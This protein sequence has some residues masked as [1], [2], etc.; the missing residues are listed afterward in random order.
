MGGVKGREGCIV[1]FLIFFVWFLMRVCV[2]FVGILESCVLCRGGVG[3]I[4]RIGFILFLQFFFLWF[5]SIRFFG[6]V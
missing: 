1:F 3:C 4:E 6:Y 2:C 5:N